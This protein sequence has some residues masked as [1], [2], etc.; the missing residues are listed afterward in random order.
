LLLATLSLLH[1]RLGTAGFVSGLH[2]LLGPLYQWRGLRE[3]IVVR[4]M[5]VVE[6]VESGNRPGWRHWLT[7][8]DEGGAPSLAL[9]VRKPHWP[10]HLVFLIVALALG[11]L[12][13]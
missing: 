8:G 11:A 12:L 13:L 5:L 1:E 10:D 7:Q 4:M 9:A 2:W 6:L 3:R